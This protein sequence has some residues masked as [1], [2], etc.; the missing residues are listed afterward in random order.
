MTTLIGCIGNV[1]TRLEAIYTKWCRRRQ[2]DGA[3]LLNSCSEKYHNQG[4]DTL[5]KKTSGK[6]SDTLW[7]FQ[8][9][10]FGVLG[11]SNCLGIF[12]LKKNKQWEMRK[13]RINKKEYGAD[14]ESEKL[15]R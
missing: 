3:E 4:I 14:V 9:T 1:A 7:I 2:T 8:N 13:S 6:F 15:K 5:S 12:E 10:P 11:R